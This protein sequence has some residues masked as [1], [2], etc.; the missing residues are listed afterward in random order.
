MLPY[1][2][3]A[4][5]GGCKVLVEAHSSQCKAGKGFPS[6]DEAVVQALTRYCSRV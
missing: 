4:M 1:M 6:F 3:I 2:L 5:Q